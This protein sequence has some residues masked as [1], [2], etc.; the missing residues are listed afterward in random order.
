MLASYF[1]LGKKDSHGV[2]H[3]DEAKDFMYLP[4]QLL[5]G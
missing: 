4:N 1:E 2:I 3:F 5:S